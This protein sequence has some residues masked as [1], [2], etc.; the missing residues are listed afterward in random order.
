MRRRPPRSTLFPYTTLFR[1]TFNGGSREITI[2]A[3]QYVT[4][5]PTSFAVHPGESLAVSVW[6]E[7]TATVSVH[8][9]CSGRIDSYATPNG[10]GNQT[11]DEAGTSLT[12]AT[13]TYMRWLSAVEVS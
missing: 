12:L 11:L 10:A 5:D 1:S 6:V 7:G 13:T 4:S 3:G 8:Y 2:S 9:C